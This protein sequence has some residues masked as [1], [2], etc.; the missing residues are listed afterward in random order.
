MQ[1]FERTRREMDLLRAVLAGDADAWK[2]WYDEHYESVY[3]FA[4]WRFGGLRDWA[5]DAIQ[6]TWLTAVRRLRDFDPSQGP[7]AAC[8]R[9]IA[10]KTIKNKLRKERK[11]RARPRCREMELAG[12][13]SDER[14]EG[15]ERV[16]VALANLPE[17]YEAVLRAKYL[18]GQSVAAIAEE[19]G[20]TI[21]AI[22]S[23][24][25]RARGAFRAAFEPRF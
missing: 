6:E 20:E 23:L 18:D 8:L 5:D 17:R 3:S 22:E 25:T 12:D 15:G 14:C 16:A 21:K 1:P 19:K 7:F 4:L 9:G 11:F 10:A 24:L 2:T 13:V